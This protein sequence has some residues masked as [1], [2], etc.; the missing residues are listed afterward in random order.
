MYLYIWSTNHLD[1]AKLW[2]REHWDRRR[3][4]TFYGQRL[5]RATL[6]CGDSRTT[7]NTATGAG[8]RSSP[9]RSTAARR[10][11]IV[12]CA[13]STSRS[14]KRTTFSKASSSPKRLR[15]IS[16]VDHLEIEF[17]QLVRLQYLYLLF[18]DD[19]V[20]PLDEWVFN[21]E[22]HPLPIKGANAY[23]RQAPVTLPVSNAS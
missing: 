7:R 17:N 2:R 8:R 14:R 1:S 10:T 18:S 4:T 15:W 12:A 3:S 11:D 20:L 21:T 16:S 22:A 5:S 9:W 19:S 13:T 6:C 23:Y